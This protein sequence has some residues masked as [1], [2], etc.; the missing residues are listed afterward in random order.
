MHKRIH[1]D[2]ERFANID[3]HSRLLIRVHQGPTLSL[4]FRKVSYFSLVI[5]F[6][7]RSGFDLRSHYLK[8]IVGNFHFRMFLASFLSPRLPN[9]LIFPWIAALIVLYTVPLLRHRSFYC[10]KPHGFPRVRARSYLNFFANPI[11]K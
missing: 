9:T 11:F 5:P 3:T 8:V 6:A 4:F 10:N 2:K 1:M 7:V